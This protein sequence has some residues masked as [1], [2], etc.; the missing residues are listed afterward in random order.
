MA[1]GVG[2]VDL[3]PRG[4]AK[5]PF[6]FILIAPSSW[7]EARREDDGSVGDSPA[8]VRA[9]CPHCRQLLNLSF[10]SCA[11]TTKQLG[12]VLRKG[13][14]RK[15][16]VATDFVS[17]LLEI[18]LDVRKEPDDRGALLQ[19]ALELGNQREGFGIDVIEVED[20][21]RRLFLAVLLHALEE[22]F[23]SLDELHLHI[24]LARRF[25]NLR[26]EEQ[27]VDESENAGIRI[28][29]HRQRFGIRQLVAGSEAGSHTAILLLSMAVIVAQHG[30]IAVVHGRAVDAAARVLPVALLAATAMIGRTP[31][32]PPS[33]SPSATG[34]ISRSC[35]HSFLLN[36]VPTSVMR[37]YSFSSALL[38][39]RGSTPLERHTYDAQEP[40]YDWKNNLDL[41]RVSAWS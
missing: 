15:H 9:F 38:R 28:L 24:H 22:V 23:V 27:V 14:A 3:D 19:L 33:A 37:G 8:L 16:H 25:L 32:A 30:A 17:L 11:V 35:I 29:A 31:S 12:K 5:E 10:F 34:G 39:L 6:R 20:D 36:V 2:G 13:R 40:R 21:E 18:S 41:F 7:L 1:S 4:E 26:Q